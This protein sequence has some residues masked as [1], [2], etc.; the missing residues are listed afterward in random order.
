[1]LPEGLSDG[2]CQGTLNDAVLRYIT[3]IIRR[4][5]LRQPP[6]RMWSSVA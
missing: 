1:M 2:R 6:D 3:L 5:T 4:T